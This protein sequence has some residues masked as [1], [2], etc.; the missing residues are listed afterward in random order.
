[1]LFQGL[2]VDGSDQEPRVPVAGCV[3]C[4]CV[5][6]SV[7]ARSPL[8]PTSAILPSWVRNTSHQ[9]NRSYRRILAINSQNDCNKQTNKHDK[10]ERPNSQCPNLVDELINMGRV[11]NVRKFPKC[12]IKEIEQTL[13]WWFQRILSSAHWAYPFHGNCGNSFKMQNLTLLRRMSF[14]GSRWGMHFVSKS[15]K[16][17]PWQSCRDTFLCPTISRS[18]TR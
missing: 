11:F 7:L 1:M 18:Y 5:V 16:F 12:S 6:V 4:A 2:F 3:Q 9:I 14:R 17:L 15:P 8:S 13:V 10:D